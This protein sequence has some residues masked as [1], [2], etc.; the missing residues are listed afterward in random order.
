MSEK[1]VK[2]Q[3]MEAEDELL[4]L[5][6]N[7]AKKTIRQLKDQNRMRDAAGRIIR[8]TIRNPHGEVVNEGEDE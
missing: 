3:I 6:I 4:D 2:E 8:K 7:K 1:S 5:Q